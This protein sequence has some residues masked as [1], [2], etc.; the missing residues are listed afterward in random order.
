MVFLQLLRTVHSN[1]STSSVSEYFDTGVPSRKY[2]RQL[3]SCKNAADA[4]QLGMSHCFLMDCIIHCFFLSQAQK[5]DT[6]VVKVQREFPMCPCVITRG[7][8]LSLSLGSGSTRASSN[9][10]SNAVILSPCRMATIVAAQSIGALTKF[11]FQISLS[12][13]RTSIRLV[14][15]PIGLPHAHLVGRR[16]QCGSSIQ[17]CW[18]SS[19]HFLCLPDMLLLSRG[20]WAEKR[21]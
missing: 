3:L 15:S 1:N 4:V 8:G 10:I 13:V 9:P 6:T 16:C 14:E 18:S 12:P 19:C 17:R 11:C 7:V 21:S 2:D 20:G 5:G